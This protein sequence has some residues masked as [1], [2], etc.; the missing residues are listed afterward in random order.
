M[1]EYVFGHW[2][3]SADSFLLLNSL[4]SDE[5]STLFVVEETAR[6][7]RGVN[8][9]DAL[10]DPEGAEDG[11][12][13]GGDADESRSTGSALVSPNT[14][15]GPG[16]SEGTSEITFRRGEGVGGTGGFEDEEGQED[17]D[18]G[19]DAGAVGV[20]VDAE[21][22]EGSQEDEDGGP[23]VVEREG[24]MDEEFIAQVAG[25]VILLDDIV[26]VTDGR[27]DEEGEDEGD[28]VVSTGPDAYVEGVENDEQWETPPYTIDDHSLSGIGELE[29][30]VTKQQEV[31]E[32]PDQESPPG[33]GEIS[34]LGGVVDIRGS[35]DGVDVRSEEK[36]VN[37][38][39][40]DFEKDTVFPSTGAVVS[41]HVDVG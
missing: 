24:K 25:G 1:D 33:G 22:F 36:E 3:A 41:W 20:S 39:V 23:A 31:N 27:R 34:F 38:D 16:D 37:E 15:E 17:E 26:D 5:R 28:D 4:V 9:V 18:L 32:G 13:Q 30:D 11:E 7:A 2:Y 14:E 12:D 6:A 10:D 40:Y 19:P 29:E 8:A 21:C 35:S